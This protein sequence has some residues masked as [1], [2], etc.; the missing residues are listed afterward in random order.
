[1][2]TKRFVVSARS[3]Q[4]PLSEISDVF[5]ILLVQVVI[6]VL[7]SITGPPGSPA[8]IGISAMERILDCSP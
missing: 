3:A 8:V 2:R 6:F 5:W 1:M 4:A 7:L